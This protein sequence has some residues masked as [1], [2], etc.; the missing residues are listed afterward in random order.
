MTEASQPGP[1]APE[2]PAAVPAP[3]P[4]GA[5]AVPDTGTRWL[6]AGLAVVLVSLAFGI[7]GAWRLFFPAADDPQHRLALQAGT[8]EQ[9]EQ[10]VATLTR[11]DQISRDAN[12]DLQGTLAERDEEIAALRA[13]VAFYERFVGATAQRRGL[14]VHELR[15][16]PRTDAGW[17][18]TATLTQSLNRDAVSQGQVSL[19][20]EGTRGGRLET[21]DWSALRQQPDATPIE[22]SFKYF[23]QVE[24]DIVLPAGF[25]PLRVIVRLAP[26]GGAAVERGFSWADVTP[27]S[28]PG[29]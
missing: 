8:I 11:S 17:H 9:L 23:Q 24:G 7:W 18:Y 19:A 29:A 6:V 3:E 27:R 1:D 2:T 5:E 14:T 21:L 10:Q 4:H 25:Q 28:E 22:Y 20:V 15:L 12:R 16:Q 26:A 13:D